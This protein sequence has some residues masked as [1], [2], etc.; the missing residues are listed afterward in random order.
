MLVSLKEDCSSN[1]GAGEHHVFE[2]R[3]VMIGSDKNKASPASAVGAAFSFSPF[4]KTGNT[5][6]YVAGVSGNLIMDNGRQPMSKDK[7][8]VR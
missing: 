6:L 3:S 5:T 2:S 1:V 8:G 4:W 7:L